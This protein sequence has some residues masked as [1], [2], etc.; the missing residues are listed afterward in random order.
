MKM[1]YLSKLPKQIPTGKALVHN[2]VRPNAQIRLARVSSL[3]VIT[4]RGSA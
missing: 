3:A 4:E 1:Q 2:T